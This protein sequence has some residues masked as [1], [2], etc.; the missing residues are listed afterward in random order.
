MLAVWSLLRAQGGV[1]PAKYATAFR[2]DVSSDLLSTAL[3]WRVGWRLCS[4]LACTPSGEADC[5][6]GC[7]RWGARSRGAATAAAGADGQGS[8]KQ[9]ADRYRRTVSPSKILHRRKAGPY[10]L[11]EQPLLLP[12]CTSSCCVVLRPGNGPK[13]A[14]MLFIR[15]SGTGSFAA[16]ILSNTQ[17]H[18]FVRKLR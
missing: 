13:H 9:S 4:L 3:E 7:T 14:S 17:H 12:C 10:V 8:C 18:Q 1:D 2:A 5:T 16:G 11:P 6:I 15:D